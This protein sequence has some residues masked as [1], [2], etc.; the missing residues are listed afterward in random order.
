MIIINFHLDIDLICMMVSKAISSAVATV[1]ICFIQ[2]SESLKLSN[3]QL[4]LQLTF[5]WDKY[6]P[7]SRSIN[8]AH[9]DSLVYGMDDPGS[10]VPP[11]STTS[12]EGGTSPKNRKQSLIRPQQNYNPIKLDEDVYS[13]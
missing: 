13:V 10:Y 1:F 8:P 7:G 3:N 4:Y 2:N 9:D 11:T 5:V 12:E 6:H